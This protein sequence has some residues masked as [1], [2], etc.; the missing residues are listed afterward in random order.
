MV[1]IITLNPL[2][3]RRF[4]YDQVTLDNVNRLGN[5][6]YQAGGKGINVARQLKRL[7]IDSHNLILSGGSNGKTLRDLL[8]KENLNFT[9]VH[10]E[11]QTRE[12]AVII[13]NNDKK[14][15]SFFSNNPIISKNEIQ[16]LKNLI[17]KVIVNC[18]IMVISGSSPTEES[19]ELVEFAISL[20]NKLDK[21]S[22]CDYYGKNLNEVFNLA[23]TVVHNNYEELERYLNLTLNNEESIVDTLQHLYSKGIKRAY[24]TNGE[25]EFYAQNFDYVYKIYPPSVDSFDS[26]GCGDAFVAGLIYGW[27][28]GDVFEHSLKFSTA[29]ASANSTTSEVCNIELN[30]FEHLID[31]VRVE[32][33][34]KKI[35]L[36]DDSPTSH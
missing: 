31:Q 1:L 11:D 5:V 8:R 26:T 23:P 15:F 16:S 10:I 28:V 12:A 24:L 14:V 21:V 20:A 2:L 9:S 13:S 25:K 19:S 7:G 36:I 22:I 6:K 29:L 30:Q 17:S 27:K 34:G 4:Y 32:Q 18:E 35:K 33:I 3:E